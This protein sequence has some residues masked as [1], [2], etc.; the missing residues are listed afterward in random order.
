M[1]LVAKH[2]VI[3][4]NI[5]RDI[6]KT[7]LNAT[8]GFKGGTMAYLFYGLDR[9][10][11]DLDFDLLKP[12]SFAELGDILLP[13][14]K[15]YG[16]VVDQKDKNYTYFYLLSYQKGAQALKVEINK[17]V[18]AGDEYHVQNFYGISVPIQKEDVAMT[19]KMLACLERKRLASRDFFD[20]NYYLT[21][22]VFPNEAYIKN[23]A[24]I[25]L[26]D[27]V[28][29]LV[30]RTA[31]VLNEKNVLMGLGELVDEK[32]KSWIKFKL[33][34]ELIARLEFML[35]QLGD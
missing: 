11:V 1:L 19:S 25:K 18:S 35:G 2:R 12:I 13:I 34:K 17:K 24:D 28:T 15:N 32:K 6:Y 16:T 23:R 10:S 5:L 22:G 8:L 7:K 9:F 4:F 29:K 31:E 27:A 30:E 26:K 33:K 20:V 21:K 14:L 3:I